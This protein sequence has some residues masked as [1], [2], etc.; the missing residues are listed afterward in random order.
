M[1]RKLSNFTKHII[2]RVDLGKIRNSKLTLGTFDGCHIGHRTI[3]NKADYAITFS[4]SPKVFF[5]QK[6]QVL[7]PVEEKTSLYKNFIVL[8]FDKYMASLTAEKFLMEVIS[9]FQPREII[10]GWDFHFGKL[11][12]GNT[13][14]L[15]VVADKH[16]IKVSIVDPIKVDNT[17]IKST[18]IRQLVKKG[19]IKKANQYLGYEYSYC[20]RVVRGKG[21]GRT[22]GFPT[23]NLDLI[24][25]KLIPH[26]GV[27]A[28]YVIMGG[29][30]YRTAISITVKEQID[31]EGHILDFEGDIYDQDVCMIFTEFIRDQKKF[32]NHD[33]LTKQISKDVKKIE[34]VLA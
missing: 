27:Y 21:V 31:I 13:Q 7:T 32:A 17:T 1:Q 23:V 9:L 29:N 22:L 3:L 4:P 19:C 8:K 24:P 10:I 12:T 25:G 2:N 16:K 11:S 14:L 28:G 15:E 20:S 26:A 33:L 6:E 30:K 18:T 5:S 34:R